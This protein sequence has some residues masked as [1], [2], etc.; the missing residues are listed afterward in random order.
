VRQ[1]Q[2]FKWRYVA[3]FKD[4]WRINEFTVSQWV[5]EETKRRAESDD[6]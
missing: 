1:H 3:N 6:I 5:Q 2:E 4:A